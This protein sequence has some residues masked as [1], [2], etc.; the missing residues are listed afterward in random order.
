MKTEADPEVNLK[1]CSI[2]PREDD[3]K[4]GT[5]EGVAEKVGRKPGDRWKIDC[6]ITNKIFRNIHRT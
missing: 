5:W 4:T 6:N 3:V 2:F 1:D